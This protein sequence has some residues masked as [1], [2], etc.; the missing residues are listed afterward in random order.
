MRTR[1]LTARR[2]KRALV[3]LLVL[4]GLAALAWLVL[5]PVLY[6]VL[7][8]FKPLDEILSTSGSL[9]PATWTLDN[10][11]EAWVAADFQRA[12]V[13]SVIVTVSVVVLG[14]SIAALSGYVLARN[15]LW[16]S[17]TITIILLGGVFLAAGTATLYPR[18]M[19]ANELGIL[20]LRGIILAQ[21]AEITVL[22]SLI[23]R[24]YWIGEPAE[25]EEAARVDGCGLPRVFWHIVL[26]GMR[27][28]LA[29]VGVLSLQWSWNAFQVPL[30]FT[31]PSPELR[32]LTVTVYSLRSAGGPDA[33]ANYGV[34]FAGVVM[35]IAP[36]IIAFVV[37]QRYFVAGMSEGALKG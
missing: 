21:L 22:T 16:G 27:P 25:L 28:A 23:V 20:D 2:V 1:R 15:L 6:A 24:G 4:I 10:Y 13:N 14:T 18:F 11:A 19:I 31:L 3:A 5:F 7:A 17:R 26:P 12:V 29:T 30:A 36:I 8:S 33:V 32:T 34:L 9:V 35:A 37:A